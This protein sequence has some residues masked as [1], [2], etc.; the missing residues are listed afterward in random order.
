MFFLPMQPLRKSASE[1]SETADKCKK[2]VSFTTCSK[3][4]NNLPGSVLM[5]RLSLQ[6]RVV[7]KPIMPKH[8]HWNTLPSTDACKSSSSESS[9]SNVVQ[10]APKKM[11]GQTVN[12]CTR[13][14]GSLSHDNQN[15]VEKI[16]SV[17]PDTDIVCVTV[18]LPQNDSQSELL[19]QEHYIIIDD[20]AEGKEPIVTTVSKSALYKTSSSV[21]TQI[22]NP[23]LLDLVFSDSE[24]DEASPSN[25]S[26]KNNTTTLDENRAG[27]QHANDCQAVVVMDDVMQQPVTQTGLKLT[28]S[29][30][31][32]AAEKKQTR[33][34]VD[35]HTAVLKSVFNKFAKSKPDIEENL[36]NAPSPSKGF[37]KK[38]TVQLEENH[39]SVCL[40]NDSQNLNFEAEPIKADDAVYIKNIDSESQQ[41]DGDGRQEE[42]CE[43]SELIF[44]GQTSLSEHMQVHA[45]KNLLDVQDVIAND[46]T[47]KGPGVN[48]QVCK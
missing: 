11:E 25:G 16:C 3:K 27:E 43:T 42:S 24:D 17:I 4:Q 20:E 41:T 34:G 47:N 7:L 23:K 44:A 22:T 35:K 1:E 46:K 36:D 18:G 30:L 6:P 19:D 21:K 38:K 33:L 31:K 26:D 9:C 39:P 28:S 37:D 13:T 14:A 12:H 40:S 8:M 5:S 48:V 15:K 2:L 45:D 32:T 10:T 29:E